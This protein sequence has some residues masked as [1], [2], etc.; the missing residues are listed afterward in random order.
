VS[1]I[2]VESTVREH[3]KVTRMARALN[4][5]RPC[6]LG[7]L[8]TLWTWAA[9]HSPDGELVDLTAEELADAAQWGGDAQALVSALLSAGLLD[10]TD[11][12]WMLHDWMDYADRLKAAKRKA[13][14]R[15]ERRSVTGQSRDR[16]ETVQPIACDSHGGRD[17]TDETDGTDGTD[18]TDDHPS[19]DVSVA[20][21]ASP[22]RSPAPVEVAAA[23]F[24]LDAPE[25]A[26]P[27]LIA[28]EVVLTMPLRK[29]AAY[30]VTEGQ[31]RQ[32]SADYPGLDVL[33]ELRKLRARWEADPARRPAKK[34]AA[35][36]VGWLT[37]GANMQAQRG[38]YREGPRRLTPA[39]AMLAESQAAIDQIRTRPRGAPARDQLTITASARALN[40]SEDPR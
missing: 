35:S 2:R 26:H 6:A 36:I 20:G 5:P 18:E 40:R 19:G 21:S 30:S 13:K 29:G 4:I 39:E 11:E 28:D 1:W 22:S 32:W 9:D 31:L 34:P 27:A 8:V 14:S 7:Y 37:Q 33:A 38:S 15:A 25:G 12:G 16:A 24:A 17:G 23:P 10:R 3:R